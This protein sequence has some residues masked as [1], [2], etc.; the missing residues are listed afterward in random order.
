MVLGWQDPNFKHAIPVFVPS[1]ISL[2]QS[3]Q[4][5]RSRLSLSCV[6]LSVMPLIH[7]CSQIL[8]IFYHVLVDNLV[9]NAAR[10]AYVANQ[11]KQAGHGM[12]AGQQLTS[13]SRDMYG[14]PL[15]Q[16]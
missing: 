1:H 15:S 13:A 2:Q 16:P 11:S 4:D 7:S 8:L 10:A 12:T 6:C 9:A 14:L 5:P 3:L